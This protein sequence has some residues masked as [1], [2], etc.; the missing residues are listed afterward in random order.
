MS[1]G[2]FTPTVA[3][4]IWERDE[5]SCVVCGVGLHWPDRGRSW[6]IHHRCPR[7]MGGSK[8]AWIGQAANGIV[9]CGTG[10]T[11]CHGDVEAH[12]IAAVDDGL[13]VSRL[14]YLTAEDVPVRMRD[15]LWLL[16][17]DGG[18]REYT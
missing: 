2:R 14:G 6:S 16:D 17:N 4:L 8:I 12:R 10:T 1:K 18:R 9:L 5:G 3:A 11:G 13:L 7:G 15:G